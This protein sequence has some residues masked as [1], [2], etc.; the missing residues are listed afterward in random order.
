MSRSFF[1]Q[2]GF[3]DPETAT[4]EGLVAV[5]GGMSV[6]RLELA[7]RSGI[8]P[9][10]DRPV[11]WWSPNP[12]AIFELLT[13]QPPKRLM[14][15]FKKHSFRVTMDHGFE[16]VIRAC[17]EETPERGETWISKRFI[18]SYLELHRAGHAHSVEVW[19]GKLLVGGVYG[20][21]FGGFFAGESMFYREANASK[22]GLL[23]LFHWLRH[24]GFVLFDTQVINPATKLLGAVEIPRSEYLQRL[25]AALSLPV[26]I[27]NSEEFSKFIQQRA[28][29]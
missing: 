8:F 7:Y 24:R 18:E 14:Q 10:T 25:K 21:A 3:P 20:V 4:A 5:G 29:P 15:I 12:R 11:T 2:N 16:Q 19:N 6:D 9:W 1:P 27:G 28:Q 23:T 17:A 13:Y 26:K 22:I